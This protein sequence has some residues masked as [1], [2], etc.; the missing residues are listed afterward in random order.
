MRDEFLP[1]LVFAAVVAT[2]AVACPNQA[3]DPSAKAA[4]SALLD[5]YEARLNLVSDQ[6]ATCPQAVEAV[7]AEEARWEPIW[8]KL[9][10]PPEPPRK[11]VCD[12]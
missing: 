1:S 7:R 5:A 10:T 4:K 11:L 6:A 12:P 8:R 9:N 2:L 3:A